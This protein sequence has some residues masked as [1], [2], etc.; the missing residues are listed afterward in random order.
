ME[1]FF[2]MLLCIIF[3]LSQPRFLGQLL[4]FRHWKQL[5]EDSYEYTLRSP[6]SPHSA[7]KVQGQIQDAYISLVT[8]NFSRLSSNIQFLYKCLRMAKESTGLSKLSIW[9]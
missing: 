2:A 6:I 4:F 1:D 8:N 3:P 7:A 5:A 9:N